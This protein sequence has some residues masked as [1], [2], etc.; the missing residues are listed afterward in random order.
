MAVLVLACSEP[1]MAGNV[2][3]AVKYNTRQHRTF[4]E[5]MWQYGY[6]AGHEAYIL[7]AEFGLIPLT[8]TV[9]DYNRKM[10]AACARELAPQIAATLAQ[11]ADDTVYV[12]GGKLYRDTVKAVH[13]DVVDVVGENRGCGDHFS[14]LLMMATDDEFAL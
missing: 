5:F 4:L 1:K 13:G 9:P 8:Q 11:H 10:D 12:Y 3:A 14:E 2:A 7:S 6:A